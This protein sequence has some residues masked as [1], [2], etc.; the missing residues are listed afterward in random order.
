MQQRVASLFDWR[1]W[2]GYYL[3]FSLNSYLNNK[4]SWISAMSAWT[5]WQKKANKHA[6][7]AKAKY[8]DCSLVFFFFF[9][10]ICKKS[11]PGIWSSHL[12]A[13]YKGYTAVEAAV[14]FTIR[15]HCILHSDCAVVLCSGAVCAARSAVIIKRLPPLVS[16]PQSARCFL[17]NSKNNFSALP[18][19][20]TS[21]AGTLKNPASDTEINFN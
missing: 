10:Q 11:V 13:F 14:R 2:N 21:R 6:K 5:I 18:N 15:E 1:S 8:G 4:H 19:I 7:Q 20:E 3:T 17:H 16:H 9:N 12:N